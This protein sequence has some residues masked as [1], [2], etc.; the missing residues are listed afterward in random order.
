MLDYVNECHPW[1]RTVENKPTKLLLNAQGS[2][3]S[4]ILYSHYSHRR[5]VLRSLFSVRLCLDRSAFTVI[6]NSL[7]DVDWR[8]ER[9]LLLS[10]VLR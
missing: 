1:S 6:Y 2:L 8:M 7:Q 10:T 3:P 5:G 9:S 4:R